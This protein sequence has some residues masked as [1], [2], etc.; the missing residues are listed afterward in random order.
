MED[1]SYSIDVK[2]ITGKI[3]QN[4]N[5][6]RDNFGKFQKLKIVEEQRQAEIISEKDDSVSVER[7]SVDEN[8][9]AETLSVKGDSVSVERNSVDEIRASESFS[10]KSNQLS[11][12][13]F[14]KED[15][16]SIE[17]SSV[18]NDHMS[19]Y[20]SE[21][22]NQQTELFSEKGDS[23]PVM[24]NSSSTYNEQLSENDHQITNNIKRN[25]KCKTCHQVLTNIT[26]SSPPI[27]LIPNI[28]DLCSGDIDVF[29][30][31]DCS[32]IKQV[33]VT[34][35]KLYGAVGAFYQI[36][37]FLLTD[38]P[39]IVNQETT[40]LLETTFLIPFLVIG[41]LIIIVLI[42]FFASNLISFITFIVLVLLSLIVCAIAY[43]YLLDN[44]NVSI[45]TVTQR[46]T[47]NV[48]QKY[49]IN[50]QE[51]S[52][53]FFDTFFGDYRIPGSNPCTVTVPPPPC[54][55]CTSLS[56]PVCPPCTQ[57]NK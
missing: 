5:S 38:V 7:N 26:T 57:T 17:R 39:S 41:F 48:N 42:T 55:P 50:Q 3:S 23:A 56:P 22:N 51:I 8:R 34:G 37:A 30:C 44:I 47:D 13:F 10:E 43:Y 24:N 27:T 54:P 29:E 11:E 40:P 32:S 28:P 14:E 36:G 45:N 31:L 35:D 12:R 52:D 18:D 19:E 9:V 49:Q 16:V 15:F 53:Y 46:I 1:S 21:K 33:I 6:L 25:Q 2:Y 20:F 4:D